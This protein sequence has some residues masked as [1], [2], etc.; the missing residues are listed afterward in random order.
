MLGTTTPRCSFEAP[1]QE[2][3]VQNFLLFEFQEVLSNK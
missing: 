3:I 2:H 1:E